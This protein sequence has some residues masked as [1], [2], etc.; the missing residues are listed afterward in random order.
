MWWSTRQFC[1]YYFYTNTTIGNNRLHTF[2]KYNLDAQIIEAKYPYQWKI[3]CLKYHTNPGYIGMWLSMLGIWKT[4]QHSCST[5]WIVT[6]EADAKIPHN[7]EH[8]MDR[9]LRQKSHLDVIWLDNRTG[10]G[11]GVSGCCTV[12]MAYHK[13][14][15]PK[16]IYHFDPENTDA[17]WVNYESKWKNR[18]L[19][20]KVE[21]PV[22]LTDFYLANVVSSNH[23]SAY[24]Y[25]IV[26]HPKG[27]S[28]IGNS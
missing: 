19:N 8:S 18:S 17:L 27:K 22:C 6:L 7:F 24:R 10:H 23:M 1:L 28:E 3:D 13:R 21:S 9:L 14:A 16:L 25:G 11:Q 26:R 12:G 20:F 5:S 4:S 2:K 15:I